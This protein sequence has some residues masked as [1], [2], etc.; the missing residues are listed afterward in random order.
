M[1]SRAIGTVGS[2]LGPLGAAYSHIPHTLVPRTP[3]HWASSREPLPW[4]V[5]PIPGHQL[6]TAHL[7]LVLQG[8][9]VDTADLLL[10]LTQGP[11]SPS[12]G[13]CQPHG[14]WDVDSLIAAG[15]VSCV[16]CRGLPL[17]THITGL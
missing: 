3:K 15:P 1:A 9:L 4:S 2:D 5:P 14:A 16:P 7:L 17:D 13:E 11:R 12:E 10:G 8:P 6:P